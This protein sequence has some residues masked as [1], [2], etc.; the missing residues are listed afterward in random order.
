[1]KLKMELY[2]FIQLTI[3]ME[4][5]LSLLKESI[6]T[7]VPNIFLKILAPMQATAV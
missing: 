4:K 7:S 6:D 1:M 5:A 3:Y 2:L